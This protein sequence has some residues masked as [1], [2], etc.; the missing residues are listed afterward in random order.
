MITFQQQNLAENLQKSGGFVTGIRPGAPT[1]EYLNKVIF[2]L[3]FGGAF[4]LGFIAVIPFLASNLTNIQ[5]LQLR[6]TS[7]LILVS[8]ALDTLRQLEAQLQ[9]R[10]YEGFLG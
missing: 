5:A 7:L 10:N 2:R 8:V 6:A 4:F 9:M 1:Q 3:T